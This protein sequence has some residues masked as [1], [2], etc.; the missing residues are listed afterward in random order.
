MIVRTGREVFKQVDLI[1]GENIII[2]TTTGSEG[3]NFDSMEVQ[4]ANG[5]VGISSSS[6]GV[7]HITA[8]N[9]Y[10]LYVNGNRVGA[11]GNSMGA[12]HNQHTDWRHTDAWTFVDSCDTPTTYA[13]HALDSEGI[14]AVIG[15][16]THCGRS[17]VTSDAWKCAP[18]T[19]MTA[20]DH[21]GMHLDGSSD[22]QYVVGPVA[23]DWNA[24]R[25]YCQQNYDDVS[26]AARAPGPLIS[27]HHTHVVADSSRRFI[28]RKNR[29]WLTRRARTRLAACL[30]TCQTSATKDTSLTGAGSACEPSQPSVPLS[31]T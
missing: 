25:A 5:G 31:V 10:I 8:D 24:A 21:G 23:M 3:P 14:A 7:I 15:D 22:K 11:G 28:R 20:S 18:I 4:R 12:A 9:G 6:H 19:S 29:T 26:E 13:I 30:T 17:V 27:S 2:L 16:F 1:Q